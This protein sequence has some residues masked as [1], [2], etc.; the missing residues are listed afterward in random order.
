MSRIKV[1]L[2]NED[3]TATKA[4]HSSS[5]RLWAFVVADGSGKDIAQAVGQLCTNESWRQ[6]K[7]RLRPAG[8]KGKLIPRLKAAQAPINLDLCYP[9]RGRETVRHPHEALRVACA[10][11]AERSAQARQEAGA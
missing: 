6:I 9:E 4:S 1:Y 5:T 8:I 2:K 10:Q 3:P 11:A 7:D